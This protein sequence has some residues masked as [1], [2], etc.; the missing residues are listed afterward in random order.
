MTR[1]TIRPGC[2]EWPTGLDELTTCKVPEALNVDGLPIPARKGCVAIVGTRRPTVVGREVARTF[3]RAF[4]EAGLCVVS[5][6]ALGID[7]QAHSGALEAGGHTIAVLGCGLDIDYPKENRALRRRIQ[8]T[9]TLVSEYAD[10]VEPT[11]YTFPERN[12]IIAGLCEG[13]VVVE[14]GE[15]SGASITARIALDEGRDIFA[16]PGS[17]RNPYAACPNKLIRTD[18]AKL[19]TSPEHVFEVLAPAIVWD[20][21][22]VIGGRAPDLPDL[23]QAILRAIGET[24]VGIEEISAAVDGTPGAV[25][26]AVAKLEVRGLIGRRY[27]GAYEISRGG[28]RAIGAFE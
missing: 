8:E 26:L 14:G 11:T 24:P 12:R 25:A 15:R 7:S 23:E 3:G 13:V 17:V 16:V 22:R 6:M 5:G 2:E 9:G 28:L 1:R 21:G 27:T 19:V 18:S 4:A 10:G 20:G